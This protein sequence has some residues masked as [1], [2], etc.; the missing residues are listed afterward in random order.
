TW[1]SSG[2]SNV[3]PLGGTGFSR[4]D[5]ALIG[6]QVEL[7]EVA[8]GSLFAWAPGD[9]VGERWAGEGERV[10]LAV[11]AAGVYWEGGYL[12]HERVVHGSAQPGGVQV[13]GVYARHHRAAAG[14]DELLDQGQ[15]GGGPQRFSVFQTG[16]MHSVFVPGAHV[17]EVDVAE[18]YAGV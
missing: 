4:T 5:R 16:G 10:V 2:S 18:H 9:C 12:A 7:G 17:G 13:V 11:L 3:R 1:S 14:G 6:Q 15:G 8:F